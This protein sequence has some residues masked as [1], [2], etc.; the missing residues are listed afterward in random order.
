MSTEIPNVDEVMAITDPGEKNR[1]NHLWGDRL[2]INVGNI[3]AWIFPILMVAIVTQVFIRKAGFNQAWLDDAQWWMYG[4]AM[5]T[6]FGYA[7]TTESHVRVDILHQNYS[8]PRKARIEI[9][10]H[11]WLLLPFMALMTDILFHYAVT[12]INAREGSDSPNGLHMLYL[13][14]SSLPI[15]FTLAIIAS[16]SAMSRHLKILGTNGLAAKIIAA[17]PF[18]WFVS[19]RTIFYVLWWYIRLTNA[20]I[21]TRRIIKEPLVEHTILMGL[22]LTLILLLVAVLRGRTA[23]KD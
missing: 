16:W 20:E 5:L 9:F 18:I 4:F 12:S 15:L 23:K 3:V 11:G 14:K 10:A 13:L 22:G 6:G 7:I 8:I 19:E 2:M 1:E 17:F 21:Q